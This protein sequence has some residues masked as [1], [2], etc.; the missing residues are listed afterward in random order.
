[1]ARTASGS[2][3]I[4]SAR[5]LLETARM[6]EELRLAQS[7]LLPLE[8]G[9]SIEQTARAIGRSSGATCTMRTRFAKIA[10]GTL[11]SPRSKRQLRNRANVD[12]AQE[13]R[14]L[15][16]AHPQGDASVREDWKK[17]SPARWSKS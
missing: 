3:H 14:I 10:A 7:V 9:L 4:E 13:K 12:L 5:K 16:T 11:A 6:A 2:E 15:D 17:N 1:M 8:L